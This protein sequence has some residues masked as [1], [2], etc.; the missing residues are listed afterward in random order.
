MILKDEGHAICPFQESNLPP[1]LSHIPPG[2]ASSALAS[3]SSPPSHSAEHRLSSSVSSSSALRLAEA[4]TVGRLFLHPSPSSSSVNLLPSSSSIK[5][6]ASPPCLLL[7]PSLNLPRCSLAFS[8]IVYAFQSI[9]AKLVSQYGFCVVQFRHRALHGDNNLKF[10]KIWKSINTLCFPDF[11]TRKFPPFS[12]SID[13]P[14]HETGF[15]NVMWQ[16]HMHDMW[17]KP[18]PAHQNVTRGN[19]AHQSTARVNQLLFVEDF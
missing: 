2:R 6:S 10:F 14:I 11:Q 8:S 5:Q 9:L 15:F 17:R 1:S 7:S 19:S 13:V 16:T 4:A 12:L 18:K 3:A